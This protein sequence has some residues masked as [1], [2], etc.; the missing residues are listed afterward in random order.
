MQGTAHDQICGPDVVLKRQAGW[1]DITLKR[2]AC[3]QDL[4]LLLWVIN[5]PRLS[6]SA[7]L[8]TVVSTMSQFRLQTVDCTTSTTYLIRIIVIMFTAATPEYVRVPDC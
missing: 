8:D 5:P 1:Q 7:I 3:M 4:T 2:Q 6:V